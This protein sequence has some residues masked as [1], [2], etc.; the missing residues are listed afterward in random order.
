M[1]IPAQTAALS[2]GMPLTA[3]TGTGLMQDVIDVDLF[4]DTYTESCLEQ[5]PHRQYLYFGLRGNP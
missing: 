1:Y 4:Y 5:P 3:D 2:M